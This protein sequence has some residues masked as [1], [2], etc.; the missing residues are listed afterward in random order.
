[1]FQ[2]RNVSKQVTQTS[3]SGL[4]Q[5]ALSLQSS[6]RTLASAFRK[7]PRERLGNLAARASSPGGFSPTIPN[8]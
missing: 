2:F 1:M 5:L 3:K 4:P 6:P 7:E 8:L